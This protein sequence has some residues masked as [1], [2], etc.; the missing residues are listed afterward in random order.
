MSSNF[1]CPHCGIYENHDMCEA[2]YSE[3]EETEL[4]CSNCGKDF[5]V[6]C[7]VSYDFEVSEL[8][9]E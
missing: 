3:Y 1:K 4:N 8:E 9:D 6:F 7:V 2:N 5:N